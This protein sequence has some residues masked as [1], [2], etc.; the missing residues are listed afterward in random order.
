MG[1]RWRKLSVTTRGRECSE[2]E[3][4]VVGGNWQLLPGGGGCGELGWVVGGGKW[5][6]LPGGGSVASWNG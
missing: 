6:L 1:S 5:Q 4:V 2:L 3:W